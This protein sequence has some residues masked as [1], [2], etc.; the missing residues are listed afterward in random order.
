MQKLPVW[1]RLMITIL[2]IPI[3]IF[4]I[5]LYMFDDTLF[6]IIM[7]PIL[8]IMG[9]IWFKKKLKSY[10][11][12]KILS[13]NKIEHQIQKSKEYHPDNSMSTILYLRP[14]KTDATEIIS[15]RDKSG[16]R[17]IKK[18]LYKKLNNRF[19][20]ISY[21]GKSFNTF[22]SLIC[23]VLEDNGIPVAIGDPREQLM[24][25]TVE[26]GA[27]RIYA[28]DESWRDKAIE[29]FNKSE[30]VIIYV[31]FTENIKWEINTAMNYYPQ[32][33][34]FIPKIY[35]KHLAMLEQILGISDIF[36]IFIYPFYFWHKSFLFSKSKRG[37]RYYN[38]WHNSFGFSISDHVSAVRI[39]NNVPILYKAKNGLL[40][41]QLEAILEMIRKH[42]NVT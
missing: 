29:L 40:T 19:S 13:K 12:N 26:E 16:K 35:N 30:I 11:D 5:Y 36:L 22:E 15:S 41:S 39:Y 27:I 17:I 34:L 38:E 2:L 23:F 14:F 10:K 1:F 24:N 4:I 8:I 7:S 20:P 21:R 32:K 31:D 3:I 33:T 37:R 28:D 9:I 42:R 6:L 18:S 25:T